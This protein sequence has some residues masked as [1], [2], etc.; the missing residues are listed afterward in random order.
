M[1]KLNACLLATLS[2]VLMMA[3]NKAD[4]TA[5]SAKVFVANTIVNLAN[6]TT[7]A[8]TAYPALDIFQGDVLKSVPGSPI[9]FGSNLV[10]T[11]LNLE[12]GSKALRLAPAFTNNSIYNRLVNY[13]AG[14]NYTMFIYD[15]AANVKVFNIEDDLTPPASGKSHI[16]FIHSIPQPIM[17][18]LGAPRRDTVDIAANGNVLFANRTF[19]DNAFRP[20]TNVFTAVDAGTYNVTVRVAGTPVSI[21]PVIPLTLAPGKIYTVIARLGYTGVPTSPFGPGVSLIVHN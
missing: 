5:P 20:A 12:A 10:T 16:R 1:Q 8:T 18:A 2:M 7:P 11:S 6:S 3:C 13:K 4:D 15:F 17:A 19:G 14:S 21:T 9:P